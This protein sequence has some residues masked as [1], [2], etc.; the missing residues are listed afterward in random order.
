MRRSFSA[1]CN[2][3]SQPVATHIPVRETLRAQSRRTVLAGREVDGPVVSETVDDFGSVFDPS[4]ELIT[5][6]SVHQRF[7]IEPDDPLSATARAS[8]TQSLERGDW[9]I[10]TES[11]TSMTSDVDYF[12]L[13]AT[14]RVFE[15]RSMV[16][17]RSWSDKIPREFQ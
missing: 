11:S 4:T 15:T 8:W 14:L 6:S 5:G 2:P 7:S 13:E 16:L 3:F 12:Y 1:D 17:E 9:K 10:Y